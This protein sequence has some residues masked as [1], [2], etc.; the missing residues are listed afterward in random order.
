MIAYVGKSG[1]VT[2][3]HL[4]FRF[5]RNGKAIDPLKVKSPTV[6]PVDSIYWE[7]FLEYKNLMSFELLK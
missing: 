5:Y 7:D 4:D 1:L 6:Q 3:P 2:G